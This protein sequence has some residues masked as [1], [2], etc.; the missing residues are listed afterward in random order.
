MDKAL[1]AE[2]CC[3][4]ITKRTNKKIISLEQSPNCISLS[5]MSTH[6]DP[7]QMCHLQVSEAI[8]TD[9]KK[10]TTFFSLKRVTDM[11]RS[12]TVRA[13]EDNCV[14]ISLT[15]TSVLGHSCFEHND[16]VLCLT[17]WCCRVVKSKRTLISRFCFFS[18]SLSLFP[19]V[20]LSALCV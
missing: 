1:E 11:L 13:V 18:L 9:G 15:K 4:L 8:K 7:L 3:P 16:L 12:C 17:L 5:F 2:A 6:V 10:P 20:T 19:P 14:Y